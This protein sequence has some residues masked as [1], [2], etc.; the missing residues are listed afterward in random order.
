[1]V[2]I[3][4][5][6]IQVLTVSSDIVLSLYVWCRRVNSWMQFYAI[7]GYLLIR[8]DL[9]VLRKKQVFY[10]WERGRKVVII[11]Y[12]CIEI[13]FRRAK[14]ESNEFLIPLTMRWERYWLFV[15]KRFNVCEGGNLRLLER[16]R[17]KNYRR[18]FD[19]SNGLFYRLLRLFV[20]GWGDY[21]WIVD[22]FW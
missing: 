21:C 2:L 14:M 12:M 5:Y 4:Y 13:S 17:I 8:A 16:E 9:M 15:S 7:D 22:D 19:W 18:L 10:F 3:P 6:L 20:F 11:L 1:M